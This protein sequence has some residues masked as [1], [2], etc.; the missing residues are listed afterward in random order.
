MDSATPRY[1]GLTLASPIPNERRVW[2]NDEAYM[3]VIEDR[4]GL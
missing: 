1:T 2:L 4:E 3:Y